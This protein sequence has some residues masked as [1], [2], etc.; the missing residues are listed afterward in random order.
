[1]QLLRPRGLPRTDPQVKKFTEYTAMHIHTKLTNI[2]RN[3]PRL[4]QRLTSFSGR[5]NTAELSDNLRRE[6]YGMNKRDQF[7]VMQVISQ[8]GQAVT[9]REPTMAIGKNTFSL[10]GKGSQVKLS[11]HPLRLDENGNVQVIVVDQSNKCL[12]LRLSDYISAIHP[13]Q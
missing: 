12:F 5:G 3:T 13:G 1:M 7:A 4:V 11:K 9:V 8:A 2:F 10:L 6:L